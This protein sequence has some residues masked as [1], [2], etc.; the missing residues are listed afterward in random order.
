MLVKGSWR[1]KS[2]LRAACA[3]PMRDIV[4]KLHRLSLAG[5]KLRISPASHAEPMRS[6]E[7]F[8]TICAPRL[9][10][11]ECLCKMCHSSQW[12]TTL[13]IQYLR[14][15]LLVPNLCQG[16]GT[17]KQNIMGWHLE[18]LLFI[19][20]HGKRAL[21]EV[22]ELYTM[23]YSL[24]IRYQCMFYFAK[25]YKGHCDIILTEEE[26]QWGIFACCRWVINYNAHIVIVFVNLNIPMDTWNLK[27]SVKSL[28]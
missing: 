20:F 8:T 17:K 5:C 26:R 1:F 15:C 13:E 22:G 7:S 25:K 28:I 23:Q 12:I 11:D 9:L 18:E 19:P 10:L 14:R 4:K 21:L 24:N 6:H 2:P 3:Q 27:I 16:G